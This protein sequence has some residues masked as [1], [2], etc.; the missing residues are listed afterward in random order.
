MSCSSL[1]VT[2]VRNN[3]KKKPITHTGAHVVTSIK[4]AGVNTEIIVAITT[5][6]A[7]VIIAGRNN[8]ITIFIKFFISLLVLLVNEGV[9]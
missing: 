2:T 1:P 6:K 5:I 3:H 4:V 7:K 8:P 9:W